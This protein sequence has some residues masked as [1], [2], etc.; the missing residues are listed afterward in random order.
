MHQK[1]DSFVPSMQYCLSDKPEIRPFDP[2]KTAVQPYPITE[3]QPVYFLAESFKDAREK[4]KAYAATIPRPFTARYNPY[5]QCIEVL[6]SKQ[7][8]LRLTSDIHQDM[9]T[10]HDAIEKLK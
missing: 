9:M 6:D 5:T 10:L 4:I 1:R 8:I 3:M 7:Q 2:V